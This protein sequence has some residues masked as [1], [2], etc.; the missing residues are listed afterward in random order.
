MTRDQFVTYRG[1]RTIEGWPERI[2]HAQQQPVY[3]IG[4]EERARVPYGGEEGDWGADHHPCGDCR[5]IKGEFHV[6]GCDIERCPACG[7]QV[8]SCNCPYEGDDDGDR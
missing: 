5:V 2:Q 1:T 8:I 3:V 7:G 4:G 6:T